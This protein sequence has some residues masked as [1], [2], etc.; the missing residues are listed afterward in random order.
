MAEVGFKDRLNDALS[1]ARS[2]IGVLAGCAALALF[3]SEFGAIQNATDK[4]LA[5]AGAVTKLSVAG[6]E[7]EL[8]QKT[9]STALASV[10]DQLDSRRLSGPATEMIAKLGPAEF[11]RLMDIGRLGPVCEYDKASA[12]MRADVAIDYLLKEKELAR[13]VANPDRL[14]RVTA[15]SQQKAEAGA[16]DPHGAATFCYSLELTGLGHDVRT[17]LVQTFKFAFN[18]S[19]GATQPRPATKP[20]AVAGL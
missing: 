15:Q 18:A 20:D 4:F 5:H 7:V 12:Q 16:E 2:V 19:G 14:T 1:A 6:F 10:M 9:V 13:L 11:A 3:V 17:A 8:D